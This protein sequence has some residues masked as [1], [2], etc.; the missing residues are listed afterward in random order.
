[1]AQITIDIPDNVVT[2][3]LEAFAAKYGW[4]PEIGISKANFGRKKVADYIKATYIE[5]KDQQS[6]VV[7]LGQAEA[8]RQAELA[9]LEKTVIQ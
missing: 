8:E 9:I 2:D 7:R 1:M 5:Y 3:V 4:T 6:Q